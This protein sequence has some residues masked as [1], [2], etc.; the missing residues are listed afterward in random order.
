MSGRSTSAETRIDQ[1]IN[2]PAIVVQ[3]PGTERTLAPGR[4]AAPPELSQLAA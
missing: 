2:G 4:V 1:A 3:I